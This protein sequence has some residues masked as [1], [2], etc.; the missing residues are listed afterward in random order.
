MVARGGDGDDLVEAI[1]VQRLP[2]VRA[3]DH[4][5][6]EFRRR[7]VEQ[8]LTDHG[9]NVARAAAA[10]GIDRR[11]FQRIRAKITDP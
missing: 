11:Y 9:G 4:V 7:Y 10:S 2:F 6:D 1:L 5:L 8:A 3:R